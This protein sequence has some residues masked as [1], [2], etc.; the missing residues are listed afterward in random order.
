MNT[1]SKTLQT[2]EKFVSSLADNYTNRNPFHIANC[3]GI[4]YHFV[5]FNKD[6]AALSVRQHPKDAGTIYIDQSFGSYSR[7]ILCAHEL[8]HLLF[9]R[10]DDNNLFDKSFN[11]IKEYEANYFT[12]LLLPQL[13]IH[14]DLSKLSIT[15]LNDYVYQAVI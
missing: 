6:P 4:E 2:I 14:T 7:K 8:G 9:H 1:H 10:K 3:H 12:V 13:M 15:E 11:P 5:D